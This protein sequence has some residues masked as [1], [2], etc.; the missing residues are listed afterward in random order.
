M[1]QKQEPSVLEI[2]GKQRKKSKVCS[3]KYN[4]TRRREE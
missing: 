4:D 2:N 3:G 1:C